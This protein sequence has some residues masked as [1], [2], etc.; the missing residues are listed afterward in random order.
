[1]RPIAELL[2]HLH[3]LDIKLWADG[4]RLR[5]DAP[6]GALTRQL[7][8]ELRARKAEMVAYLHQVQ[9]DQLEQIQ[10]VPREGKLPLSFSQQRLWFLDQ[11]GSGV[12][13]NM[14][15]ALRLSGHLNIPAFEAAL[16]EVVQR[17][18]SLRTTFAEAD[19]NAHQ[20][21]HHDVTVTVPLI[22]LSH[23][24]QEEQEEQVKQ[25]VADEAVLPFDLTRDLMLRATLLKLGAAEHV[26]LLTMH[27]IASDGW[28]MGILVRE[29]T[30]F[31]SAPTTPLPTLPIQYADFAVWQRNRLQGEVLEA[32]LQYWKKQLLDA[33]PLHQ[34]PTD[35]ARPP[36][37]TFEGRMVE[38]TIGAQL[39]RELQYLSQQSGSTLFMTL[40]AGFNLLMFRYSGTEDLVVASPIANRNRKEIEPLIGF[41]V[42]TL[43][44]RADLSG[45]PTFL[46]L[47][48]QV[49]QTT[50]DAYAHQD[51]P[52]EYLVEELQPERHLN[53]NPVVQIVFALQN[54]PTESS[55]LPGL[56]VSPLESKMQTVRFDIEVH[57]W[58]VEGS[59]KGYWVYN[60]NLFEAATMQRMM[61]HF[62]SVLAA[63]VAAPQQRI[64][65]VPLLTEAERH[66]ILVEWND[67]TTD[68]PKQKCVH[69]LFE[70]QVARTPEATALLGTCFGE[71]EVTYGELN[72]RANQLAHHLIGLGVGPEVL[73]GLMVERSLEMVVALLAILKA[74]GAYVPLDPAYP[75]E[76]LAFM[77][78]DTQVPVLLTQEKFVPL[79]PKQRGQDQARITLTLDT[80]WERSGISQAPQDNPRCN[81]TPQNLAYIMYT[82]GSTG[83]PKGVCIVH[84]SIV[85]LVKESDYASFSS[86][87][88]FLQLAPI[89]FDASTFEIWGPLLNGGRLV[90]MPPHTPSLQELGQAIRHYQ[91]TTLWLTAGLFHLMVD[92]RLDDLRPLRQLLA[93]GDV[94]SVPHVKRVLQELKT[95][96]LI[97][98]Y[99]PTE[100]T[101]F[102]CCFPITSARQIG[103][104]VPI[105]QPIANT[106]V[107]ILDAENK[108]TPIGVA[109]FLF[110][111]GAGL[112]RGYHNRPELTQERFIR[113][114]YGEGRLYRTGDLARW[115]ADENPSASSGHRIEFLGRLDHQ[116]K[117]RG[118]RIE[119]GEIESVLGSHSSLR[120]AVV[121]ARQ[122][123]SQSSSG[124]KRLV[125]YLVAETF[126]EADIESQTEHVEQWQSLYEETYAQKPAQEELTFNITGWNSSYT[127]QPIPANEMQEWV[128]GT[129]VEISALHGQRILEIGCGTGLLLS[130]LAPD[131][132]KYV[133]TDYSQEALDHVQHLI[134]TREGY[135]HVE[136]C[137]AL[138]DEFD[139][140][141]SGDFDVVI[142]NSVIQYF[143]SI[144]YL[145]RVLEGAVKALKPGGYIY[146]GDVRNYRLLEA[147]HV[148]V[149]LY[150]AAHHMSRPELRERVWQRLRD[151][152]E[153]LIDPSFF[154]AL[155]Q[156]LPQLAQAQVQLKRG[157]HHNELT[158]FR[159]QVILQVGDSQD[160]PP[161]T[162]LWHNWRQEQW[163]LPSLRQRLQEEQ[164]ERLGLRLI[165]NARVQEEMSGLKWLAEQ[166]AQTVG[167]LRNQPTSDD[168]VD[169]ESLWAL[170]NE[171]GYAVH[172]TYS[173]QGERGAMDVIFR[174]GMNQGADIFS[175]SLVSHAISDS[176]M[177]SKAWS[178]YANNPLLGKR[179]RT[180]LPKVRQ[181]L[182]DK[183]PDYM[184]PSAFVLLE[185]L[186]LTPNG[187]V[188]RRALPAP[189][190][191][192]GTAEV[193]APRDSTELKLAQI[194]QEVLQVN[195]IGVQDDFFDLG[196]HS[197]LAVRLMAHIRQQFGVNLPLATLF[198][199]PS[200]ELLAAVLQAPEESADWS[201]VVAMQPNG[202]KPAFFCVPGAGGN[203]IYYNE[204][205][206]AMG[207]E[208]PF[209]GLQAVGLDGKSQPH[210]TIEEMATHYV[211]AVQRV[212][213]QGPYRLSGHSF[214][215]HVAFEMAQQLLKA[216]H[217][218][219]RLVIFDA[220]APVNQ[221]KVEQQLYWNDARWMA[222]M[223]EVFGDL[224]G[225]T[226]HLS[227]ESLLPLDYE[228]QLLRFKDEFERVDFLPQGSDLEQARGWMQIFK[229]NNLIYSNYTPQEV[230]PTP[231]S[232]FRAQEQY[233][234]F[235]LGQGSTGDTEPTPAP[236]WG[237]QEFAK[238]PVELIFVPGNHI[239]MIAQPHV[240]VLAERLTE[241]LAG[242]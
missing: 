62:E 132:K 228:E 206:R 111:G 157:Q 73:V 211:A 85:R 95:C 48:Q 202:D 190:N 110:I 30:Q 239:T 186:P 225:Q 236:T 18:E 224:I 155:T 227:Y 146:V 129:V 38:F 182:Q 200:I 61:S 179:A 90:I 42:N 36:V 39:T 226:L 87:E 175:A 204:L 23:L 165:P 208:Q 169:P 191:F 220:I 138:A 53:Y 133:G 71:E 237:W 176:E 20:L 40:L 192:V 143:P 19:G 153:L 217:E 44:L 108:P 234:S 126:D 124:D 80:E 72:R 121:M 221:G 238:G 114:P 115:L 75:E 52:F 199:S 125:A 77:L 144:D 164:P 172:I 12:A 213:P 58:E 86:E 150:Q 89:S 158:R 112:A 27:H 51:L 21:I 145:L 120:E 100:C 83:R 104:T 28:S 180:L 47:L 216:G 102:S 154:Y 45:N 25:L 127:G 168:G 67:T 22:D 16:N 197:L 134:E 107:Y 33:P 166:H 167:Q 184:I 2:T 65:Q 32:Q 198:Q 130:R 151:E 91:V 185:S 219:A 82:S 131:C 50:Q 118:F 141:E 92:E 163:S 232:L 231:I 241:C 174:Q 43:A 14:P 229:T 140:I 240:R 188:D 156:H 63:V 195:P 35:R 149:Q 223:A 98:G 117:I 101:T 148:S 170:G 171:L 139:Q 76:R 109:G 34:L 78:E 189:D 215:A 55:Q 7:R 97:N 9:S 81:V 183:L 122:D 162:I 74:G 96:Q 123:S 142:L 84:E 196:G 5:Y 173:Q 49:R 159:Y 181:D 201:S 57:L 210:T 60:S 194:W 64:S 8:S 93:G 3:R 205:V 160:N 218:V 230:I 15:R 99:G 17:H 94:L 24:T 113:N 137:H 106:Q 187:K 214:G 235:V 56:S 69:Q 11:L 4:E 233:D 54:A 29:M 59:L 222:F 161:P 209:Y 37:Q 178:A 105:G 41:F 1:M 103:S 147:Y 242:K 68:Y 79:L 10:P 212:Q 116:V 152:E 13:Y 207:P 66:Q 136:L 6:K 70:E 119:L 128:D 46:E 177:A 135:Q 88:V 26:I 31:Y 203:V 193:M